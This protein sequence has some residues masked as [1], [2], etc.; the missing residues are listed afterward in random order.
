MNVSN[1]SFLLLLKPPIKKEKQ[2]LYSATIQY[3]VVICLFR[4]IKTEL[5]FHLVSIPSV[6][7]IE[8]LSLLFPR[9]QEL[10][11]LTILE[12]ETGKKHRTLC[13]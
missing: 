6:D 13:K 5:L 2:K 9:T 10:M 3:F 8:F 11:Q 1:L 7:F 12:S 4:C